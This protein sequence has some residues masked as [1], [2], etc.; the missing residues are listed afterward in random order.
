[1]TEFAP[2]LL[3][4]VQAA[5]IPPFASMQEAPGAQGIIKIS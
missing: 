1:V 5:E 2:E 3:A 4:Q